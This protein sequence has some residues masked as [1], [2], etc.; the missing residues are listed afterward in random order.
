VTSLT[1]NLDSFLGLGH[2]YFIY[3]HP[4]TNKFHF[5][6]WDLDLTFGGMNFGGS[7]S[8]QA[9][10]SIAKPYMGK[11]RLAERVLAIQEY[12]I[13]YRGHLKS[14]T[15]GA[16]SPKAMNATIAQLEKTIKEAVAKEPVQKGGFGIGFGP[17]GFGK[18]DDLKNFI[19]KRGESVLA[20]LDGKS[21]GKA[22]AG[23]GFGGPGKGAFGMGKGLAKPILEAA[24]TNKDSKLSLDEFKVAAGKLFKEAGGDEKSPVTEA[25]LIDTINRLMP[26]PK[27]FGDFKFPAPPKGFGPGKGIA[28][29]MMKHAGAGAGKSLTQEAFIKGAEKLFAQWD[30][31]KS[32]SLN[33]TELID[34]L[35]QFIPPPDFGAPKFGPNPF[36][37][38]KGPPAKE[39]KEKQ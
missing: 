6:P 14:L 24:D 4:K 19:A 15:E 3:L 1:A 5:I 25:A 16:F 17:P 13:A 31:N 26:V 34:G 29:A 12:D 21:Q 2:N 11:N 39:L 27:G 32:G 38:K 9:E 23:F 35:N 36:D 33:E 7:T 37:P 22:I 28:G 30:A 10:W 20:Q 8:D 18:K